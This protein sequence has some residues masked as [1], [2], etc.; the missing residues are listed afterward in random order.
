MR[1]RKDGGLNH[2]GNLWQ[3][4]GSSLETRVDVWVTLPLCF[5][6]QKSRCRSRLS[7]RSWIT[8][9]VKDKGLCPR[10]F[11]HPL[12]PR[13]CFRCRS[14]LGVNHAL[15]HRGDF[16]QDVGPHLTGTKVST[17]SINHS[18]KIHHFPE[19]WKYSSLPDSLSFLLPPCILQQPLQPLRIPAVLNFIYFIYSPP[20][21]S[22]SLSYLVCCLCLIPASFFF[23]LAPRFKVSHPST[24]AEFSDKCL[25]HISLDV[26]PLS[27]TSLV[28][29]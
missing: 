21:C 18:P 25:E 10:D 11:F 3:W 15:C 28:Y 7:E 4:S 8:Y 27:C 24:P 17:R 12:C 16:V 9:S 5:T 2:A 14:R 23:H 20:F 26:V 19:F 1:I 29:F 13:L 6:N 22:C